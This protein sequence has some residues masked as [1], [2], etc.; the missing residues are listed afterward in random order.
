MNAWDVKKDR[1][2]HQISFERKV[3]EPLDDP[4]KETLLGTLSYLRDRLGGSADTFDAQTLHSC[5]DAAHAALDT[6]VGMERTIINQTLRIEEMARIANTD[7][8]TSIYNRRGF[9]HEFQ[10]VLSAA[11]RYGETGVLIYVDLD[12][13]KPVND[14]YGHAAGDKMLIEVA[15]ILNDHVRPHDMVARLGG[16]E[17]AILLTR[18]DWENGLRR[19]ERIKHILNT[20]YVDWNGKHIA[21][22]AS[23][24]FQCYG[25]NADTNSLLNEADRAMYQS[26]RLRTE[27]RT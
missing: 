5:L 12:G 20:H 24:G 8:L 11:T 2:E 3:T 14:T 22:R 7:Q 13:F 21:V 6:A 1:V 23:L 25:A 9:E 19:A 10:R 27:P 26:K 15:R 4:E 16:D 18:T 17:F